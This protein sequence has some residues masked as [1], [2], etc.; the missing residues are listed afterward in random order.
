MNARVRLVHTPTSLG[1]TLTLL[2]GLLMQDVVLSRD[3]V[4]GL[5]AGLLTSNGTPMDPT[6]L[7][8]RLKNNADGLGKRYA[9]ELRRNYRP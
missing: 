9:S 1:Y 5:M 3:E 7:S 8:A 2:V 4:D 6:R